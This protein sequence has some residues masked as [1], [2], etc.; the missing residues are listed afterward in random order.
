MPLDSYP[1]GALLWALVALIVVSGFFS[2]SETAMMALNRY[3]LRH[4]VKQGRLGARK[5][6]ELLAHTDKLLGVILLGNTLVNAA[7]ATLTGLITLHYFGED[8]WAQGIGTLAITFVLLVFAEITPKVVGATYAEQIALRLSFVLKPLLWFANPAVWFVNLFVRAVLSVLRLQ[9]KAEDQNPRL[10]PEELRFLVL[11]AGHFIPKKHQ[12]ILLNLFDL[13]HITIEDLMTPSAKIEAIDLEAPLE[14]IGQQLATSYHTRLLAYKGSLDDIAGVLHL[15]RLFAA[16]REEPISHEL[17]QR[18]LTPPYFVP[19]TTPV[20]TQLGFFQEN[21]ERLGLVV[22][23]YGE[24]LG[25]VTLEDI[26]E[27]MIGEFTTS[28]PTGPRRLVWDADGS[29]LVEGGSALR[30]LNRKLGLLLPL[31]GPKTLSGVIVEYLQDIPESGVCMVIA[32]CRMEIV[33]TQD[34]IVKVV[35]LM[36]APAVASAAA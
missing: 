2:M 7:A 28:T 19:A 35:R 18:L 9:P 3:R 21:H 23:E 26:V 30:E 31:D 29:V 6:A 32:G 17:L 8:R 33:Q 24:L 36:R 13:E 16:S 34:R 1:I 25:L 22:D 15:R 5:T 12:S 14:T 20:L 10:S 11:E 4:L 27:E